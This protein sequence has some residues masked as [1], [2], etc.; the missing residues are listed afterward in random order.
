MGQKIFNFFV[1]VCV[2]TG[3]IIYSIHEDEVKAKQQLTN[4][5]AIE[6][7][8]EIVKTQGPLILKDLG[9]KDD[10]ILSRITINKGV[11]D[12]DYIGWYSGRSYTTWSDSNKIVYDEGTNTID[13]YPYGYLT[14]R[15]ENGDPVFLS[16]DQYPSKDE[17]KKEM[18]ETL[19]H[20][21]RH[22]WQDRTGE[23]IKHPYK[24]STPHDERWIEKDANR[25]M[26]KY[27][28]SIQV[29]K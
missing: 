1:F 18:I 6:M 4:K 22:Y 21:L 27:Y 14:E 13:L 8:K 23:M 26:E 17:F 7:T 11:R 3:V 25:Y 16:K 19:A 29:N 10:G 5:Q 2:I 28:Q 24:D 20:E 15:D 12:D 9:V